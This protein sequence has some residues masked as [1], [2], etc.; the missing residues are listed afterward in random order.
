MRFSLKDLKRDHVELHAHE[1]WIPTMC[2]LDVDRP[3][4]VTGCREGR[5]K[6][7]DVTSTRKLRL[8]DEVLFFCFKKEIQVFS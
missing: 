3:L 2:I 6:I 4:L 8:L 7:W 1:K 5:L